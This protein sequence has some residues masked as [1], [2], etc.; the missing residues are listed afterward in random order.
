MRHCHQRA[1]SMGR[2]FLIVGVA[3][4]VSIAFTLDANIVR[5]DKVEETYRS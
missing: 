5:I 2:I 3:I 1:T 4:V